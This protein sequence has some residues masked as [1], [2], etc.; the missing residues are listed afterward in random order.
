[1]AS[2]ASAQSST[3]EELDKEYEDAFKL[4]FYENTLKMMNQTDDESFAKLIDNIDKMKFLRIDKSKDNIT[5]DRIK[6]LINDYR[7][8]EFEEIMTMRND[9][10]DVKVY[11]KESDRVTHGLVMLINDSESLSVLDIK[12]SVPLDELV[13]LY[14]R[15]NEINK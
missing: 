13:Q 9:G 10:A 4:F 1:M 7:S 6:K 14:N 8:E 15:V 12:G 3:T 11:I 2:I 5:N